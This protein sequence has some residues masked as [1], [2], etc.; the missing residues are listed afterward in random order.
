M[1]LRG[2][3]PCPLTHWYHRT[4]SP[5]LPVTVPT[6]VPDQEPSGPSFSFHSCRL[7][8]HTFPNLTW[9]H[10]VTHDAFILKIQKQ[11]HKKRPLKSISHKSISN[12]PFPSSINL[13][14]L[15]LLRKFQL[16]RENYL[17]FY[18]HLK[19]SPPC[20]DILSSRVEKKGFHCQNELF[21]MCSL[22]HSSFLRT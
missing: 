4:L 20:L 16:I 3:S 2:Q 13:I 8:C 21:H 1:G 17:N 15:T 14:L 22:I 11:T 5:H 7:T 6:L 18:H 10:V 9:A 12:L 19:L